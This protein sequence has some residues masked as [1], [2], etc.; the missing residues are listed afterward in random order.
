MSDPSF[1]SGVDGDSAAKR[2]MI[3]IDFAAGTRFRIRKWLARIPWMTLSSSASGTWTSSGIT[4]ISE[5]RTPRVRLPDGRVALAELVKPG[6]AGKLNGFT[7]LFE[8][9]VLTLAWQ[10]PDAAHDAHP[11]QAC[12]I[13]ESAAVCSASTYGLYGVAGWICARML[14]FH[15]KN[16]STLRPVRGQYLI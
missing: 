14:I 1:A 2:L 4:A 12:K 7:P 8:A 13:A 11:F 5:L 6:W 16:I 9:M 10:M 15:L 3:Q